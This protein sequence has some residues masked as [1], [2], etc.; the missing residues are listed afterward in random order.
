MPAYEMSVLFS[1]ESIDEAMEYCSL[2]E[3]ILEI[4]FPE[5]CAKFVNEMPQGGSSVTTPPVHQ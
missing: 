5:D 1:A 4:E 3:P 2:L